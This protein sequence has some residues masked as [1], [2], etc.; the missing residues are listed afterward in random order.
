[1]TQWI[2]W[3]RLNDKALEPTQGHPGEDAGW[4]LYTTD[5]HV[6][7]P[8]STADV[9]T[10]VAVEFPPRVWGRITGRSST[11]KKLGLLVLEG[12][13]D[14]GYRGE[15]FVRVFNP[16]D[17]EVLVKSGKRLAQ[18]IPHEIVSLKWTEVEKLGESKRNN[19]GFGSTGE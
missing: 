14:N 7:A 5:D 3:T 19:G 12:I 13:I 1:M 17:D 9:S 4:D 16:Q 18:M 11:S 6:I 8:R 15:L 2:K 10:G